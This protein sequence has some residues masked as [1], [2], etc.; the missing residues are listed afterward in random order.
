MADSSHAASSPQP[1]R[2]IRNTEEVFREV[3]RRNGY[4]P[5]DPLIAPQIQDAVAKAPAIAAQTQAVYSRFRGRDGQQPH[6][7]EEIIRAAQYYAARKVELLAQTHLVSGAHASAEVAE[8]KFLKSCDEVLFDLWNEFVPRH[9]HYQ[10]FKLDFPAFEA[11]IRKESSYSYLEPGPALESRLVMS[12]QWPSFDER[13][14][15]HIR[16]FHDIVPAGSG[17][18][19]EDIAENM[20]TSE[21][22]IQELFD[23]LDKREAALRECE[24]ITGK[25]PKQIAAAIEIEYTDLRRWVRERDFGTKKPSKKI[26]KIENYLREILE[27]KLRKPQAQIE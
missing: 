18:M 24:R 22:P 1:P 11:A 14:E 7:Q 16:R 6:K 9:E 20:V 26:E 2:E 17:E 12:G 25:G 19:R 4:D 15:A 21:Q 5:D 10:F 27:S 8:H 3:V 13:I 23:T